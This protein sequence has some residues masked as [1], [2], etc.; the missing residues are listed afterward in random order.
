MVLA[1]A[2]HLLRLA[3][4]IA[5]APNGS[6]DRTF[7]YLAVACMAAFATV[8]GAVW[9]SMHKAGDARLAALLRV[10]IRYA[11]AIHMLGYGI[12]KVF[13]LQFPPPGADRLVEP[14]GQF[15]PMAVLW[16]FIGFSAPYQVFGGL[17]EMLGGAL[18]L[19]R[20]TTFVGSLV[21]I[22]VM[23]NVVM[24]N[25]CYDVPVKILSTHLLVAA[26]SLAAP[27][28]GR[29]VRVFLLHRAEPAPAPLQVAWAKP[30]QRRGA[31]VAK[32]VVIGFVAVGLG[33][34]AT[35]MR[36]MFTATWQTDA[37][38][39]GSY[40]VERMVVAGE[41]V[42][43]S[44]LEPRRWQ[45][46][47]LSARK[48]SYLFGIVHVDGTMLRYGAKLL[49]DPPRMALRSEVHPEPQELTYTEPEAGVLE[50]AGTLDG[51]PIALRL[52]KEATSYPLLERGFHWVNEAP[53]QR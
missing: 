38:L 26:V 44:L 31:L 2:K 18:L 34:Q 6:G 51:K 22:A 49:A 11:L 8:G 40:V 36:A 5:D 10:A 3:A 19:S 52:R 45:R 32:V 29:F 27:D 12:I 1:F 35:K 13:L 47:T 53:H 39:A 7:D 46:V 37:P 42:P 50:L 17:G 16:L 25:F 4:P 9:A 43:P 14:F 41:E 48:A 23:S 30:W 21:V 28:L 33:L 15:S 20:R 24:L